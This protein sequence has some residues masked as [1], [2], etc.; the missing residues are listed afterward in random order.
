MK[1]FTLSIPMP[2]HE[3]WDNMTPTEKGKFCAAC[4]KTVVDFTNMSDRQ[5]AVFFKKTGSV[6]GRFGSTQ[7]NRELTLPKKSLPWLHSFFQ[8]A[9]PAFLL[10]LKA[11]AQTDVK[12]KVA[13]CTQP[14]KSSNDSIKAP[15]SEIQDGLLF[16]GKVV[17]EDGKPIAGATVLIYGTKTGTQTSDSGSFYFEHVKD[18][19]MTVEVS[20]VGFQTKTVTLYAKDASTV[21]LVP[22]TAQLAGEVIVAYVKKRRKLVSDVPLIHTTKTEEAFS[23]FSVFPNPASSKS[24]VTLEAKKVKDGAYRLAIINGNG[25]VVQID[26]IVISKDNKR[27]TFVLNVLSSRPYFI[28]LT[29]KESDKI[30]TETIVVQ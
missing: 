22:M 29:N 16:K 8:I 6:C 15:Q 20:A 13:V 9:L 27:A 23:K 5:I 2:C 26:E 1:K 4:Q 19:Q 14:L 17:S 11:S 10:S 21:A 3:N 24:V 7:L 30:Y 18:E 25:S 28:Q 12:G